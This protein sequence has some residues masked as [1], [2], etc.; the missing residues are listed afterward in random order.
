MALLLKFVGQQSHV[1]SIT[2]KNFDSFC[3]IKFYC[4]YGKVS[5]IDFPTFPLNINSSRD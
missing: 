5:Q 3:E 4:R 1:I 2:T